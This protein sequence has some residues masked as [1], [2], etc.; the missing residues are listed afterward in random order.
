MSQLGGNQCVSTPNQLGQQLSLVDCGSVAGSWIYDTSSTQLK[1][2][3]ASGQVTDKRRK[4]RKNKIKNGKAWEDCTPM[5]LGANKKKTGFRV[6][7]P[8]CAGRI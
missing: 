7:N 6:G 1:L 3:G 8:L 4:E 5:R 2:L